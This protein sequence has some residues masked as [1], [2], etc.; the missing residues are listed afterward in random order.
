MSFYYWVD[1]TRFG[2]GVAKAIARRID[3]S[4]GG[5]QA[6]RLDYEEM[7]NDF[8]FTA[9]QLR[10]AVALMIANGHARIAHN[11][12][13]LDGTW[14]LLLTPERLAEEHAAEE[15]ARKKAEAR[16]AKIAL[17]GGRVNRA[18]IPNE[19]RAAVFSRDGHACVRCGATDDLTLDHIKPWS[20]GGSD[21]PD[22]LQAMCR[23]CNSSKGDRLQ[24]G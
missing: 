8:E 2:S 16:A 12:P 6:W 18:P 19:T 15:S 9:N 3:A 14:L 23:T 4:A 11:A 7:A 5:C 10:K 24:R 21:T 17:R 20:L 13:G 22:N 1:E